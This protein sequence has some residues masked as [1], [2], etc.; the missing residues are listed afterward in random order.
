MTDITYVYDTGTDKGV[1]PE[2]VAEFF[3]AADTGRH[4]CVVTTLALYPN[5]VNWR[6]ANAEFPDSSADA[7]HLACV[8]GH[9]HIAEILLDAGASVDSLNWG[10]TRSTSLQFA[11]QGTYEDLVELL[12]ERGANPDLH[13][14]P[15]FAPLFFAACSG[16]TAIVGMLLRKGGN[17]DLQAE[18]GTP[19][20]GFAAMNNRPEAVRLLL[21]YGAR[22]DLK[23][24]RGEDVIE[25]ARATAG[26]DMAA[27]IVKCAREDG[28]LLTEA[29]EFNQAIADMCNGT[30]APMT[31]KKPLRLKAG[32]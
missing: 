12:L 1:D 29:A 28:H 32:L 31:L 19:P 13:S 8:S 16:N 17:P 25:A 20:L 3:T 15:G 11:A 24:N 23:N 26:D 9:R 6:R 14:H 5:A 10:D 22:T 27:F 21:Q 7:L 18:D 30:K 2:A 4:T